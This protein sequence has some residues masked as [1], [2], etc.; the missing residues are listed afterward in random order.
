ML[1]TFYFSVV[2]ILLWL[3]FRG[4]QHSCLSD[5]GLPCDG[6]CVCWGQSSHAGDGHRWD[7]VDDVNR[8]HHGLLGSRGGHRGSDSVGDRLDRRRQWSLHGD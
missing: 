2:S 8:L 3:R 6:V 4:G 5:H 1:L 7:L